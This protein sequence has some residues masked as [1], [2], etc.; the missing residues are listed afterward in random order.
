M[1][2]PSSLP[3]PAL[4]SGLNRFERCGSGPATV[5]T[6]DS[7]Q[8][9]P[10]AAGVISRFDLAA[11]TDGTLWQPKKNSPGKGFYEWRTAFLLLDT[12]SAT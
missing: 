12:V 5:R 10:L 9:R 7:S 1:S 4:C 6:S 8:F 11:V 2:T 3:V